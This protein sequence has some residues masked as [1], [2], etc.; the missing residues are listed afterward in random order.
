MSRGPSEERYRLSFEAV[1]EKGIEDALMKIRERF[2]TA[3]KPIDNF[4]FHN[5][6]HTKSVIERV[7]KLL[8]AMLVSDRAVKLGAL[9]ASYHD[10]IQD[11]EIKET[12]DG[13]KIRSRFIE[14]NEAASA[15]ELVTYMRANPSYFSDEDIEMAEDAIEATIPGFDMGHMTVIQPRLLESIDAALAREDALSD[16]SLVTRALALADLGTAGMDAPDMFAEDGNRVFREDNMDIYEALEHP[17]TLS[18]AQKEFFQK[19][20]L[21]WTTNQ[22]A[23]ARGREALLDRELQGLPEEVERNV[24]ALFSHFDANIQRAQS[25]VDRRKLMT[26]EE[27][28]R[29]FGYTI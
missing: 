4:A 13:R 5:E 19:R 20:M 16:K 1:V 12:E 7:K 24:R 15:L 14:K 3:E 6:G 9:I 17:D 27:L 25:K 11:G 10:T 29:D 23:F 2:G 28:A 26:F 18:D 22:I 21:G 8:E